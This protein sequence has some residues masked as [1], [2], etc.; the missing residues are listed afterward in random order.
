M[1]LLVITIV[2][3][4]LRDECIGLIYVLRKINYELARRTIRVLMKTRL[5]VIANQYVCI[6]DIK[7]YILV[8]IPIL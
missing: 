6:Y 3:I 4:N 2:Y 1:S 8:G 5:T 7:I